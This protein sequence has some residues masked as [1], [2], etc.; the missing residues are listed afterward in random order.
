MSIASRQE[1]L[2]AKEKLEQELEAGRQSR[3][4]A[5]HDELDDDSE[6]M[7]RKVPK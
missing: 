7:M 3:A 6:Q 1:G 2:A 4:K 5:H